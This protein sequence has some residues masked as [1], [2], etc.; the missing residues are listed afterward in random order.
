MD[1]PTEEQDSDDDIY[2]VAED[3]EG[4]SEEGGDGDAGGEARDETENDKV[5]KADVEKKVAN[6]ADL[7]DPFVD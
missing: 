7:E 3:K 4:T 2:S 5:K 6:T 1:I